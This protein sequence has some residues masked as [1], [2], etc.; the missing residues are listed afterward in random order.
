MGK[1]SPFGIATIVTWLAVALYA[2][3]AGASYFLTGMYYE[4]DSERASPDGTMIIYR[5]QSLEDSLG[6]APYGHTL[7]LARNRKI[8]EPDQGYV[9][10]AGY[11]VAPVQYEWKSNTKVSVR[12]QRGRDT[13]IRTLASVMYGI[14]IEFSGR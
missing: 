13:K 1:L 6:H 12:C 14:E 3:W 8:R 10:F 9:F 7:A 5:F 11:C 4:L 2:M